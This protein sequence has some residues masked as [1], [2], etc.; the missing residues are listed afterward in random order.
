MLGGARLRVAAGRAAPASLEADLVS[1]R[2]SAR[3]GCHSC[4]AGRRCRL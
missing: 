1:S 2:G 3:T 4:P